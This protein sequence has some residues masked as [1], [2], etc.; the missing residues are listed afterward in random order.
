MDGKLLIKMDKTFF[1]MAAF[2]SLAVGVAMFL[3]IR[4]TVGVS[5]LAGETFSWRQPLI[6]KG[7][8][9]FAALAAVTWFF[10]TKRI[11]IDRGSG[12]IE[13]SFLG[14]WRR[15]L[16]L[17]DYTFIYIDQTATDSGGMARAQ[18]IVKLMNENEGEFKTAVTGSKMRAEKQAQLISDYTGLPIKTDFLR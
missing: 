7:A 10:V 3:V 13:Q 9:F 18:F 16:N 2:V 6:L 8:F 11:I 17:S 14:I 5:T 12:S 1:V 4:T 15:R